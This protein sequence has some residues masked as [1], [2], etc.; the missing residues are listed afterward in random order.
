MTTDALFLARLE[1]DII[2][3]VKANSAHMDNDATG[4]Y[5]R[6][7]PALGMLACRR[8]GIPDNAI[9]CQAQTLFHMRYAVKHQSG[10]S[11]NEY[12]GDTAAPL[13]GTGQGSGFSSAGW[14]ALCIILLNCLDRL[15]EKDEIPGL[16]F[17]DPWGEFMEAWRASAFVDDTNPGVMDSIDALT[18]HE[19]VEEL[20][21]AG[22]LWETLLHIS[23]GCLN[24]SK[25]SWNVQSGTGLK[26]A[27]Y[28]CPYTPPIH[29]Y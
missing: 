25:C 5:D 28:S 22:Q 18:I 12:G 13:F 16:L 29:H 27:R 9:A 23:G 3:Q 19:L 14:L 10:I 17:R 21:R 20:R 24:L 8:L 1:K 26:A 15:S 11:T 7:V 2:R 4:C 6:I